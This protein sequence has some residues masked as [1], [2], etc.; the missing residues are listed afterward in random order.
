MLWHTLLIKLTLVLFLYFNKLGL[1]KF[2][3]I[4]SEKPSN[5]RLNTL[6]HNFTNIITCLGGDHV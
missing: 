6:Y 4:R 1:T 5:E 2:W 3:I